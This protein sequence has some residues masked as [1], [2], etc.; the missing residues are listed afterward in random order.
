MHCRFCRNYLGFND[1]VL[2]Q[3]KDCEF[4]KKVIIKYGLTRLVRMIKTQIKIQ[5]EEEN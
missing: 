5:E 2:C 1:I 3:N 4:L